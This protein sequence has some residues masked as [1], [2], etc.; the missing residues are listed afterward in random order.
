MAQ[1]KAHPVVRFLVAFLI[2]IAVAVVAFFVGYL[3]GM[4]LGAGVALPAV[5]SS[6]RPQHAGGGRSEEDLDRFG[7]PRLARP[8]HRCD[9]LRR[10]A[11]GAAPARGR[12]TGALPGARPATPA[13]SRLGRPQVE[14][15]TGDVLRADTLGTALAG[16]RRR[17][18]PRAQHGQAGG[19]PGARPGRGEGLRPRR[20][21]RRAS[22]ASCTS[23]ASATLP[24]TS[25]D[26]LR[27][28]QDTGD[29]LREAA[30]PVTEFRAAVIVGSGSIS[31][32]M[33]RYLTERLPVMIC[34]QW[35]YTRVQPIA[36]GRPAAVPRRGARRAR[37][38]RSGGRDR[39]RGRA[40]LRRDDAR[41]RRRAR[42]ARGTCS[43]CP[44]SPRACRRTG[45]TW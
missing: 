16:C 22:R 23:A 15:V 18:L 4:R 37:E 34:P 9:R 31:F 40:H 38:R 24:R 19:V 20:R 33:I 28:R 36:V 6:Q 17:L 21:R 32:E 39:R 10:R 13:G 45:C 2:V 14:V 8:R 1:K 3:I 35:V 42:P 29:A 5:S 25:R 26:H 12:P 41:L 27:S 11:S 30:V 43:R 7:V 44:C